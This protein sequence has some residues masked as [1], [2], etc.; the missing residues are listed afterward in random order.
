MGQKGLSKLISSLKNSNQEIRKYSLKLL[1]NLLDSNE[2]LQNL[3]CE[4]FNFNQV[5][6]VI[7]LNWIP[8]AIRDNC[9]IDGT[10]IQNLKESSQILGQKMNY[11][12]WPNNPNYNND[13]LPDPLR[14]LVGI[15]YSKNVIL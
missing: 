4:K 13:I 5:G 3:F 1:I 7:C 11:W 9:E 2:V 14:Y 8:M 15:I 6:S 12:M 10:F